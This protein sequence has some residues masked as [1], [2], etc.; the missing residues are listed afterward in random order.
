MTSSPLCGHVTHAAVECAM[1]ES[2]DYR[3][4][5]IDV[6]HSIDSVGARRGLGTF[7]FALAN[8]LTNML[9]HG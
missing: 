1:G 3:C 7:P 9:A 8:D 6:C 5:D 4:L 2:R